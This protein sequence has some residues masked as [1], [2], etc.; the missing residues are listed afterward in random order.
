[1]AKAATKVMELTKQLLKVD[2]LK[3]INDE[4]NKFSR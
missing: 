1:M 3:M 4:A 2:F